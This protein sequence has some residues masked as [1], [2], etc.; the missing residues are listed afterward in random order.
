MDDVVKL[1]E[2]NSPN[3]DNHYKMM[4]QINVYHEHK[5]SFDKVSCKKKKKKK[6]KKTTQKLVPSKYIKF[7][8]GKHILRFLIYTKCFLFYFAD[9]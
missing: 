9:E 1:F 3:N 5:E 8:I 4:Q 7:Y 6:K 2:A